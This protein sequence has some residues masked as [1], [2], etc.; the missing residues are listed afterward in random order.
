MFHV[1]TPSRTAKAL[2]SL[3]RVV[4]PSGTCVERLTKMFP[5]NK[6]VP[7]KRPDAFDPL[8][9]CVALSAQKKKEGSRV[10]FVRS[11]SFPRTHHLLYQ[12]GTN[13]RSW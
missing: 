11:L 5:D 7:L 3:K 2:G 9:D 12:R 4:K 8:E 10:K 1:S 6:T 13:D